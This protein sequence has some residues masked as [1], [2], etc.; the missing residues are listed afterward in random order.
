MRK[1]KKA[2]YAKNHQE[3][4]G[5]EKR[6]KNSSGGKIFANIAPLDLLRRS[7]EHQM[8]LY[9]TGDLQLMKQFFS[10]GGCFGQKVQRQITK[11]NNLQVLDLFLKYW[12]FI[13]AER[14]YMIKNASLPFIEHYLMYRRL[15]KQGIEFAGNGRFK[16]EFVARYAHLLNDKAKDICRG[17]RKI[18]V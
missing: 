5:I 12:E 13:P 10:V 9:Q 2:I 15:G 7:Q 16:K 11:D 8:E 3:K 14:S 4:F 18:A 6:G 17:F 1:T